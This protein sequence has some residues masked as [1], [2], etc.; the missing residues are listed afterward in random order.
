MRIPP[1]NQWVAAAIARAKGTDAGTQAGLARK[2]TVTLRREIDR[3]AV[4]KMVNGGRAIYADEMLAIEELTGLPVPSPHVAQHI[5]VLD[6]VAA[7]MLHEPASQIPVEDVPKLALADLGVGQFFA[8]R[9]QGTS[10]D[11]VSPEGSIIVVN[12]ADRELV[13]G[14][15]YVFWDRNEGTATFK[16]W[17][18]G[19]PSYLEPYSWDAAHKPIFL[20]GKRDIQ[21]IGRVKRTLLDL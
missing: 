7:G 15:F 17:R 9:I 6:W 16:R 10:M 3:A 5:S 1:L 20:K 18:G 11:R 8:L 21:V 4:N 19:D 12:R 14:G 13:N 2:L